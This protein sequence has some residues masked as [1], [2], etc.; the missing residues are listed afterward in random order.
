MFES[1]IHLFGV[2]APIEEQGV[3][4]LGADRL[5]RDVFSRICFGARISLTIGLISVVIS[6]VL[7]IILGGM[8]GYYGGTIDNLIQR[9][10]EFIRSIPEIPLIMALGAALPADLPVTTL[11]FGITIVLSLIGWTGLARVVRGRFLSLRE[12]D[13]V[14]AARL[15]GSSEMRIIMRHM[16]PSFI[17]H[18]IASLTLAIPAHHPGRDRPQ[19]HRSGAASPG[20][21]LGRAVAGSAEPALGGAGPLGIDP[22]AGRDSHGTGLQ[23]PG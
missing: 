15:S 8:S 7:G 2:D 10:I 22:R 20:H 11:Y 16:M 18:I 12:E 17:S 19:F 3:F 1:N 6:L 13:F 14:M 5:G 23:L 21:Q 9:M 4:L